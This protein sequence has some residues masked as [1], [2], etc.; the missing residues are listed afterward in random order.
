MILDLD[1]GQEAKESARPNFRHLSRP[2]FDLEKINEAFNL[3]CHF[4]DIPNLH[5]DQKE[6]LRQFFLAKN[7]ISVHPPGMGSS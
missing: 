1:L 3:V 5:E 4:F 2:W 6:A 7:Y